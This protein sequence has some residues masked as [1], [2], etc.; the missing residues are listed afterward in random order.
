MATKPAATNPAN[1]AQSPFDAALIRL[2]DDIFKKDSR[3][4]YAEDRA[5][6]QAALFYQTKQWIAPGMNGRWEMVKNDPKKPI[7]MPV[8]DYFSKTINANANSLG[9][10][11][12]EMIATPNDQNSNTRRAALAAE[13]AFDEMDKESGMD[14][15]NP[16]LAKHDVLWG[17]GC[18]KE[19]V[20]MSESSGTLDFPDVDLS[21]QAVK[22]CPNCGYMALGDAQEGSQG[23]SVGSGNQPMPLTAP[24]APTQSAN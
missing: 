4:R 19:T 9:A 11:I 15:L 20:D 1:P 23:A 2:G 21:E 16:I 17:L 13:N 14:I 12:P 10:A 6:F 24:P 7:P 3:N 18:T 22:I 5:W 8:S